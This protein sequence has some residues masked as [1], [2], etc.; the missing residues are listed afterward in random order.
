MDARDLKDE[1]DQRDY[2]PRMQM[3]LTSLPSLATQCN[4]A[5]LA[6]PK[7]KSIDTIYTHT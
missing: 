3:F 5:V 2:W 4:A 7:Q 1:K 6:L